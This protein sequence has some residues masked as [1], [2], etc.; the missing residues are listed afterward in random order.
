M[1]RRD[2]SP[3]FKRKRPICIYIYEYTY[4]QMYTDINNMKIHIR[5]LK[6]K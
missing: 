4:I 6:I 5:T 1:A 3:L 2:N